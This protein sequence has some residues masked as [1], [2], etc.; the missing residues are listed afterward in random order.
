VAAV[1]TAGAL[2]GSTVLATLAGVLLAANGSEPV[3]PDPGL[4]WTALGVGIALLGGTSAY[5]RRG[6]VGGT[7]LAVALVGLFLAYVEAAGYEVNRW[8]VAGTALAV[9][10]VVTRLVETY[11]RPRPTTADTSDPGSGGD[12]T[13]SS[14]WVLPGAGGYDTWPPALPANSPEDPVD[15]WGRWDGGRDRWRGDDHR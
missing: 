12:P 5:G 3:A 2:I 14:G 10:L 9:G 7:L 6:G 4:D 11:G 13:I 15:P 1:V 8:A